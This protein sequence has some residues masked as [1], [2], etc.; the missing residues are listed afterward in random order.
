[1]PLPTPQ[2]LLPTQF[3]RT[4][5]RVRDILH[6]A[7]SMGASDVFL[8][9]G[10]IPSARIFGDIVFFEDIEGFTS[11]ELSRYI[12]ETVSPNEFE[13]FEKAMELD[14]SLEENDIGR[15]RVNAFVQIQ[16]VSIVFRKIPLHIPTFEELKLPEQLKRIAH[17]KQGLVLMAGSMGM[18]K[19]TTLAS[20][21]DLINQKYKKHI[22]TIED[23]I[24]FVH[25][26]NKSLIEQRELGVHTHTFENAI[27]SCLR[28][29]A[30]VLLIGELR[31]PETVQMAVRA[32]ETGAL[33]LAT[34]HT[35]GATRSINRLI[36]MFPS[37]Q[38]NQIR[39]QLSQSLQGVIWQTLL[40]LKHTNGRIP[41]FEIM[42]R[43]HAMANLIREGKTHQLDSVLEMGRNE[44]MITMRQYITNLV[45]QDLV[46]EADSEG[47]L[48]LAL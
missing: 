29:G 46:N 10:T 1:M 9:P 40:P 7:I 47:F 37:K 13:R 45:E 28:Q 44:G 34:I 5:Q 25:K 39:S 18:G 17:L 3:A 32:A 16:G 23:P 35:N 4:Q 2:S 21:V 30:D 6:K 15:F 36:D 20:L 19:S 41:G 22:V 38:Q 12:H 8:S 11:P 33:V 43:N 31:D 48:G 27:K 26:N 42:F 14:F 24:E